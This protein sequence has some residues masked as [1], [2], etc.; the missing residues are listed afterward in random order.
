M[1][2]LILYTSSKGYSRECVLKLKEQLERQ[3]ETTLVEMKKNTVIPA[4]S[5]FDQVVL[6]G[7]VHAGQLSRVIR[8]F[9]TEEAEQLLQTRVA[10]FLCG[11][12]EEDSGKA[13]EM[14]FPLELREQAAA[15]GWFGGRIILSDHNVLMRAMLKKITGQPGDII[16]ERPEAVA[17]F[18]EELT[19]AG[20]A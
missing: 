9:C 4:V 7:S 17:A 13:F 15:T 14:N 12:R 5:D 10:L 6:G 20:R 3:G 16:D 8:D 11:V 2:T 1:K 18:A 19:S